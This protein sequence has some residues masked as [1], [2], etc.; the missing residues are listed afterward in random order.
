MKWFKHMSRVRENQKIA[1]LMAQDGHAGYGMWWAFVEVVAA[2][3]GRNGDLCCVTYP[4]RKWARLTE[5]SP[6]KFRNF[7]QTLLKLSLIELQTEGELYTIRIRKLLVLRDE[8]SKKSGHT[9]E[10][11]GTNS[12]PKIE[13]KIE[14]ET[15]IESKKGEEKEALESFLSAW[16]STASLSEGVIPKVRTAGKGP[17]RK[18]ILA[19]LVDTDWAASYLEALATMLKSDFL[20]GRSKRS[21]GHEDWRP[22]VDWVV[23][24]DTV[25]AIVG[26]K[27]GVY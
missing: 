7:A 3:M 12:R 21:N 14:I 2:A 19:R 10:L 22:N 27:Y 4:V 17:R 9:R 1:A 8:Y 25:N 15:E 23:R 16:N 24:P 20:M 5:V 13:S 26:G 11:L 6:R 18:H